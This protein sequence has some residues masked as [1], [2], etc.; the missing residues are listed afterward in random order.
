M[1][2][3]PGQNTV[4]NTSQI[5]VRLSYTQ[6]VTFRSVLDASAFLLGTNEKT[7][8]DEDMLFFNNNSNANNSVTMRCEQG[9]T[10]FNINLSTL[11][12]SVAK[13]ALA[14]VI[15]GPDTLNGLEQLKMSVDGYNFNVPLQ[16]RS[17]KSLIVAYI[18]R[19]IGQFKLR[20]VA[21][22]FDG[23]LHPLALYF[24][25]DAV[26]SSESAPPSQL[27]LTS[28]RAFS[29]DKKLAKVSAL[30]SLAKPIRVSLEKYRLS[31]VKAQVAF[32]LDA[33]GSMTSQFKKGNVQKVLERIT[34]LA[35]QFDDNGAMPVWVFAEKHKRYEDVTL[36][37]LDGYIERIQK[38]GK[39]GKWEILP[40][41]G[42]TNNEP[43]VLADIIREFRN[44][45]L[46]V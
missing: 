32:V 14:V 10:F 23:G 8:A 42:G 24:G 21:Q 17:E 35:V 13:T 3:L 29:L 45:K 33:S 11:P 39:K 9:E 22:G 31:D 26:V 25:V 20:A 37:N 34:A 6:K 1:D 40:G 36:D 12:I 4:I 15:D 16:G 7:H 44:S 43:P 19:H 30:V 41:L 18:Y 27:V 38:N 2:L 46:P 5:E 28:N